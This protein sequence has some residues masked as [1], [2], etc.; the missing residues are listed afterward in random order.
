[1]T[2][3]LTK[4]LAAYGVNA[5]TVL[6]FGN[7]LINRTWKVSAPQGDCVLQRINEAV[8]A[9]PEDIDFNTKMLAQ[10]LAKHHPACLFVAPLPARNG[11]TLLRI[12]DDGCYR[13]LP[14]VS[15]SHTVDSTLR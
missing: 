11:E 14:F 12:N 7:G 1:M 13:L 6:A 2:S 8:F 5:A 9:K 3:E 15:G 10:Y 4:I